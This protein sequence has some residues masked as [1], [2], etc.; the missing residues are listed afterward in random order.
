MAVI[1]SLFLFVICISF[2]YSV[3]GKS[4]ATSPVFMWSS[5]DS[6]TGVNTQDVD[7]V[8]IEEISRAFQKNAEGPLTKYINADTK[9][10]ILIV[11]VE[12]ELRSEQIPMLAHSYKT[13]PNGGAF[14]HL[15]RFVETSRSSLVVPYVTSEGFS[16]ASTIAENL[17]HALPST[18]SVVVVG[19]SVTLS[20]SKIIKMSMTSLMSKLLDGKWDLLN[21]G[22]TDLLVVSF[23]STFETEESTVHDSYAADDSTM[24]SIV[25]ALRQ[26]S[27]TAIFT[28]DRSGSIFTNR[29]P[30][31][32][33]FVKKFQQADILFTTNWPYVITQ[34]LIIMLPFLFILSLGIYCTFQLQ[35]GLKFDA[36]KNVLKHHMK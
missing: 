25:T 29:S 8:T 11:F 6:L 22:V 27:Y 34:A 15:K 4:I 1:S 14:S 16:I 3:L 10:E 7:L 31:M 21:N 9:P 18:S 23:Q 28:A 17:I 26:I 5:V 32:E 30:N 24:N 33:H 35:S 13:Q 36:E 20:S 19:D 12:P 2:Q